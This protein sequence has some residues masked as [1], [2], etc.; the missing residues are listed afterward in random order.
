MATADVYPHIE[1]PAGATAR[2]KRIPRVRVAQIVMDYLAHGWS[3]EDICRNY[4]TLQPAEVYA[5]L[6]HYHDHREEIEAE[7]RGEWQSVSAERALPQ[8]SPFA[9]R[10]RAR[11]I[12]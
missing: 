4:P 8:S 9:L 12:I 7:I 3:A 11:G 6:G 1:I 5:A 10:M 2:L